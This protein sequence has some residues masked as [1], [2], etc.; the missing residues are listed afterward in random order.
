M[1]PDACW[2]REEP[3][4]RVRKEVYKRHPARTSAATVVVCYAGPGLERMEIH[5][6][7][8]R[9]DVPSGCL[10]R[11]SVDNGR[12]WSAFEP[13][14]A[15]LSHPAGVEV[16][17]GSGPRT[18]DPVA[19]VLVEGW[20][21][22]IQQAV[23]AEAG[24]PPPWV[25][26]PLEGDRVPEGAGTRQASYCIG[27]RYNDFAYYRLSRDF[28]R[29]WSPPRQFV[30]EE[31]E[32][33]DP[34]DPLKPAFLKR[35]QAYFGSNFARHSGRLVH[36]LV[37]TSVP[38]D[39]PHNRRGSLC[40]AGAWDAEA[41]DYRWTCGRA[42]TVPEEVSAGGL[43]EPSL[44]ELRDGRLLAVWRGTNTRTTDGRKW[45]STSED[46]G[47][48]LSPVRELAFDDGSRFY[49]PSSIHHLI[50]HSVTGR[51]YWIGNISEVPPRGNWPRYPLVI[52]EVDEDRPAIRR[53]TV[54]V[55]DTR[56][57]GQTAYVEFSNFSVLED[58][59]SHRIEL[60][61]TAYGERLEHINS[62]DCCRYVVELRDL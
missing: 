32:E 40:A 37:H 54:S 18:F 16:W 2:Y 13:L 47:M 44:A 56:A 17:E 12:T 35:N 38:G 1:T 20:L 57:P 60:Y 23:A 41:G 29:T 48:T 49:S 31:G 51:L 30:Y 11:L 39:L 42:V 58:R 46:G 36:C 53:S 52:A 27:K 10:M 6:E 33:F 43:D 62:A 61:L 50:R 19:G 14:P 59:E 22:Q 5:A 26:P 55:I 7:E 25:A 34:A 15:T 21:R 9:V 45:F 4:V 24:P 28:G 3:I 8:A